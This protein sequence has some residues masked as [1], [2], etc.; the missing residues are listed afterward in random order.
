VI[1]NIFPKSL[2]RNDYEPDIRFWNKEKSANFRHGQM[3]FPAPEYRIVEQYLIDKDRYRLMKKTDSGIL[4]SR[5]VKGFAIPVLAL[6]DEGENLAAL[7]MILKQ[8]E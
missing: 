1:W 3:R 8:G 7:R 4:T 2:T 6:F 5:A